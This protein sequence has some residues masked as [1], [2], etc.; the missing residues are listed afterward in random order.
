[1]LDQSREEKFREWRSRA[2]ENPTS[3]AVDLDICPP[4]I[5]LNRSAP[6]IS[7]LLEIGYPLESFTSVRL[8]MPRTV[9]KS[10]RHYSEPIDEFNALPHYLQVFWFK[11]WCFICNFAA[12]ETTGEAW[13]PTNAGSVYH[14]RQSSYLLEFCQNK[15]LERLLNRVFIRVICFT[16]LMRTSGIV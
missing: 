14:Y 8:T 11:D 2:I 6:K 4:T 16:A 15:I 5:H 3:S 9:P 7:T 10:Q 13:N 12:E 1:V